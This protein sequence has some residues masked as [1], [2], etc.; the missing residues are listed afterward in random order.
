MVCK[1]S[2]FGKIK[3]KLRKIQNLPVGEERMKRGQNIFSRQVGK[4][5]AGEGRN[6]I[7]MATL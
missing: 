3:R 5:L 4:W 6:F 1:A 7:T 2:L